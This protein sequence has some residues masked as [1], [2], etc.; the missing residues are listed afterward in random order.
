MLAEIII[1]VADVDEAVSFYTETV[2]LAYLR[3]VRVEDVS[4]VLLAAGSTR[5]AL[6]PG[7]QSGVRLAFTTTDAGA[8]H[9]RLTRRGVDTAVDPTRVRGG[10]IL[11]FTDPWGNDLAFWEESHGELGGASQ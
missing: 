11:P 8:D 9:R 7:P 2:G 1:T 10:K 6:V 3:R 5:V 4:I